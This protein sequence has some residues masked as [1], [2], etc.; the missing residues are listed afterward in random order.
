VSVRDAFQREFGI[1][2]VLRN[3]P[4]AI[5]LTGAKQAEAAGS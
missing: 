4:P 1:S 5:V 2:S 3:M